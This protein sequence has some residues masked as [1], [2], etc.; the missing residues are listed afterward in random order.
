[1]DGGVRNISIK[2]GAV[3]DYLKTGGGTRKR[4]SVKGGAV[5]SNSPPGIQLPMAAGNASHL[6]AV[7]AEVGRTFRQGGGDGRDIPGSVATRTDHAILTA[8][9]TFPQMPNPVLPA[10]RA[11]LEGGS[12]IIPVQPMA[13]QAPLAQTLQTA[14]G[15]SKSK[16]ILAQKK[17]KKVNKVILAPSGSH[18]NKSVSKTRKIRVQ[19]SGMKKRMTKAKTIHKDSREK[20][21]AEIRKLL[22]QAKLIK[23]VKEGKVIPECVIRDIYKDYMLLRGRAL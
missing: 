7:T 20:S 4:R 10:V 8:S 1:M 18:K 15:K 9:G 2:G 21:I 19:L 12:A 3:N 23:P 16:V 22:E 5:P 13:T 11:S 6:S 14:G 17:S